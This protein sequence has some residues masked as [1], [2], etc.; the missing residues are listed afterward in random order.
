MM[1]PQ[2]IT[3]SRQ[4]DRQLPLTFE[5][6]TQKKHLT[7]G[8]ATKAS[9]LLPIRVPPQRTLRKM[10]TDNLH[11]LVRSRLQA[12]TKTV[13]A[14]RPNLMLRI[15]EVTEK[16]PVVKY[17]ELNTEGITPLRGGNDTVLNFDET[18]KQDLLA[19]TLSWG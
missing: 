16:D 5:K 11:A 7:T 1:T 9:E 4:I 3:Q 6:R 12:R 10:G 19:Q 14:Q 15:P 13:L 2:Y 18:A 8:N 17:T